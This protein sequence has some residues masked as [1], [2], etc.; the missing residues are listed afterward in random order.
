L[1]DLIL[2]S[3]EMV[4]RGYK[5]T[6]IS[7]EKSEAKRFAI[8]YDNNALIPPF[9]TVS[10][11]GEAVAESI[12]K[13]RQE[14]PFLSKQDFINRTSINTTQLKYLEKKGVLDVLD[15]EDQLTLKLF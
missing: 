5:F 6:N 3:L 12:I 9:I 13:A 15:E 1:E 14:Q 2:M 7:L 4:A 10:G 8:D 11:L